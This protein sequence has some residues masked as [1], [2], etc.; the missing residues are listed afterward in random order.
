MALLGGDGTR[1]LYK[2]LKDYLYGEIEKGNLQPNQQI[3]S[4]RE[5]CRRFDLSRTTV[6]QALAEAIAEGTFYR[7]QGKGTFV[8]DPK[9]VEQQVSAITNF[10][11]TIKSKGWRPGMEVLEHK[12]IPAD[13]EMAKILQVE[14]GEDVVFLRA[15]GK[16][17]AEPTGLYI[18]YLPYEL[19]LSI[20]EEGEEDRRKYGLWIPLLNHHA[21]K[22]GLDLAYA[23]QGFEAVVARLN[24]AEILQVPEGAPILKVTS[25]AY[26]SR[27]IPVEFRRVY[28]RGEKYRFTIRRR[29]DDGTAYGR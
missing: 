10:M 14:A 24:T 2:R 7:I 17:D 28:Y 6:R 18:I 8:A 22:L 21:Q 15:L 9:R 20:I 12:I 5:L 29:Y 13:I 19:G 23:D 16:G 27:D 25:I 3:A 4:E 11:D 1:P 26:T